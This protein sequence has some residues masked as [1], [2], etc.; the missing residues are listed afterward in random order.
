MELARYYYNQYVNV[1][2]NCKA[3]YQQY[4]KKLHEEMDLFQKIEELEECEED[5]DE[6]YRAKR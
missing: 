6:S 2:D 4:P 3:T 5:L 1:R